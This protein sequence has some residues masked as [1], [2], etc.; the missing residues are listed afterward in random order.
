MSRCRARRADGGLGTGTA[1]LQ[2]FGCAGERIMDLQPG[3]VPR[4]QLRQLLAGQLVD[5]PGQFGHVE[6]ECCDDAQHS[7]GDLLPISA[8]SHRHV[9]PGRCREVAVR[10]CEEVAE[11]CPRF[12]HSPDPAAR[13]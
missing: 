4:C 1:V 12:C 8:G 5:D 9:M 2:G 6:P 3:A 13:P 11:P 7:H 10:G